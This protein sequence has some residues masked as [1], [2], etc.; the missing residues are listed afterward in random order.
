[1][2]QSTSRRGLRSVL[3]MGAASAAAL[4][5]AAPAYAQNDA[6]ETV[7][8]T[9][10]RIPQQGLYSSSPVTAIGQQEI[11]FQGAVSVETLLRDLPAVNADGDNQFT[12]NGSAG[13]AN[14]DLRNLGAKRTLVLVDGKRLAPGDA[15]SGL[16]DL[17]QI[18]SAIVDHIEVL[19]GGASAVYGSDAVSGVVNLIT[20][21]DFEGMLVDAQFKETEYGDGAIFDATAIM[22]FNSADGRGNV[23]VYGGY[24]RRNPIFQGDRKWGEFALQSPYFSG[25][26]A[27]SPPIYY[28]GF[29]H[30]GSSTML[31][32]RVTRVNGST[33]PGA[34]PN[35]AFE[36]TPAGTLVPWDGHLF[37]FAPYNYY[38]TPNT[39][40]SFGVSGHYE[41]SKQFDIYTQL[42]FSDNQSISQLAPSPLNTTME[43]NY[44]NPLMSAQERAIL[45]P[46]G[47]GSG[48]GG[49]YLDTDTSLVSFAKR[50]AANGPRV[51]YD[52]RTAYEMVIGAK[53]DLGDGWGYDVYGA[54]SRTNQTRH[55][56]GDASFSRFQQGLLVDP[57]GNC[58]DTSNGC[59]PIDIFHSDG[60]TQA[61]VAFF[62]QSMDAIGTIE[63]W[64]LSGSLSG[65]LGSM[66]IQSPWAKSPVA[67]AMGAE[68]R[69]DYS[70][71]QP[72]DNLGTG[73][74]LGFGQQPAVSGRTH[75]S[76]GFAEVRVP[77]VEDMPF[78]S[79]LVVD[80]AY[81]YSTYS[82]SGAVSTYKYGLEWA[83]TED[84]RFRGSFQRAVRAPNI[85]ELF[86][87]VGDSANPATDP[88]SALGLGIG[89][90]VSAALCNATGVPVGSEF[91]AG[92]NCPSGQ[93]RARV[94]GNPNLGV[95]TSDSRTLGFVLTP[96]F[97][98][99]FTATV[100][101]YDIKIDGFILPPPT[102]TI[103][104]LC[105]N[106]AFNTAQD[107]TNQYCQLIFRDA[108]GAIYGQPVGGYVVSTAANI[109]TDHVRGWDFE[110]NLERDL[111]DIG[112][113]SGWGSFAINFV[114]TLVT[115][116]D[117]QTDPSAPIT[118]CKGQFGLVCGAP[119]AEWKHSARLSW[120][121]PEGDITTSLRWRHISSVRFDVLEQNGLPDS[122]DPLDARI[123]EMDYFD[124]SA[125]WTAR[126]GLDFR[127]GVSNI[128]GKQPPLIDQNT[129]ASS[130]NSGNTFPAT[131]DPV[132]RF[133]FVGA[134]LKY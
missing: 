73:N 100:D 27:V 89:Y 116:N 4:A 101:Y 92:L 12:N 9:G 113:G 60:M 14:I 83:P 30:G 37:N 59:V 62:T 123:P 16:V 102:Q 94:G 128:L 76:E 129:A 106:P 31:E 90:T 17:N 61:Q 32:G 46:A 77:V 22:G 2:S 49:A 50:L 8:V 69:Q 133:F 51:Q 20:K 65:D 11:K 63:E 118:H 124:L 55:L 35:N 125:T 93:C 18:P 132:G 21:R 68:Y 87:P 57:M 25:C 74:L 97:F 44:G 78:F 43:I 64:V 107:P 1:M 53:G 104:D 23:T 34:G 130:L 38:Q 10:S 36:F 71:F 81:R 15:F 126:P 29:C 115:L 91:T 127:G 122:A 134:S 26:A 56:D 84:V 40:Y 88:C 52:G 120:I 3:L 13:A 131:Y 96:T 95:E 67:L 121:S 110:V 114:G 99:G 33:P 112:V 82:T 58:Y 28:G 109:A 42:R 47:G 79:Q 117:F 48:P 54:Y 98:D 108:G 66:G 19:T 119:Q 24:T 45:F 105:Y 70:N 111:E 86:G 6:A 75:V 39:R 85:V 103:L 41:V 7:V 5:I 72:D 80:G